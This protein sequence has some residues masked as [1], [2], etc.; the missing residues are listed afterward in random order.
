[1]GPIN[2]LQLLKDHDS[3][4]G[5]VNFIQ[6]NNISKF[7]IPNNFLEKAKI[8]K[9]YFLEASIIN[10][11]K[12]KIEWT[13]PNIYEITKLLCEENNFN[14]KKIAN[15]L[16]NLKSLYNEYKNR[17]MENIRTFKNF[18]SY[19]RLYRKRREKFFQN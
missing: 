6:D 17:D 16:E 10:P 5:I 15:S 9:K 12:I 14:S 13:N 3:I 11:D 4:E 7:R 1:M 8:A 19:N 2:S 18:R